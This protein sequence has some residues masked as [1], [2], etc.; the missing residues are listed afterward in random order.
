MAAWQA[1]QAFVLYTITGGGKVEISYCGVCRG[2]TRE[3]VECGSGSGTRLLFP[4]ARFPFHPLVVAPPRFPKPSRFKSRCP[5][6][7][8]W[9]ASKTRVDN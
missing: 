3:G 7:A 6:G 9:V 1:R 8:G 4:K 5:D 2:W